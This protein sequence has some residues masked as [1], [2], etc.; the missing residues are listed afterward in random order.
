MKAL[1]ALQNLPRGV[2]LTPTALRLPEGM[3]TEGW[4]QV[5]A[6][7]GRVRRAT[8]WW[9]GDWAT[10]GE[11]RG[12]GDLT[13][14]AERVGLSAQT[15]WDCAWVS[16]QVEPSRRR[17]DLSWSHHR[18]VA[19]LPPDRQGA[20]LEKGASE[21]WS[22]DALRDAV[23]R[24]LLLEPGEED[25]GE[26]DPFTRIVVKFMETIT[27]LFEPLAEQSIGNLLLFRRIAL[28]CGN[29]LTA[30]R[31][32]F[33]WAMGRVLR[34]GMPTDAEIDAINHDCVAGVKRI[35]EAWMTSIEKLVADLQDYLTAAPKNEMP[36]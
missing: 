8:R 10:Y 20:W 22:R 1:N 11:G 4:E 35:R 19:P 31:L 16:R 33:E 29:A 5:G 26:L 3:D 13:A 34:I 27:P 15:V 9:I 21:G 14:V 32:R 36:G 28:I 12:Y 2:R 24:H 17:E 25:E 18:E 6:A 7:L 23:H 30:K